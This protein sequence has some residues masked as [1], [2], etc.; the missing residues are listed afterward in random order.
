MIINLVELMLLVF[1]I[2]NIN[3]SFPSELVVAGCFE[4]MISM[5]DGGWK[6]A[7][8]KRKVHDQVFRSIG[9]QLELCIA[10]YFMV[11]YRF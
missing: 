5:E 10:L 1:D 3:Y 2:M 11:G 7:S 6:G 9:L 4:V 8:C